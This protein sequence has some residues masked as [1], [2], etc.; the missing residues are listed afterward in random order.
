MVQPET[1]PLARYLRIFYRR[2]WWVILPAFAVFAAIWVFSWSIPAMYRS[3]TLI[4]VEHQKVPNEYVVSNIADD[5][6]QRLQTMTQQILSR[7]RLLRVIEQHGL[8]LKERTR[9]GTDEVI[10]KMRNDIQIELVRES[11][12]ELSAF[13]IAYLSRNPKT[14][15]AV[16]TQLSF[17][18]IEEN[19]RVRQERSVNTTEFLDS[20]LLEARRNLSNQEAKVRDFKGH[21]LGELP[22]QIQS[23]VQ[24]LSGMQ[25]RLQQEMEALSHAKQQRVYLE[26]M[27]SQFKAVEVGLRSSPTDKVVAPV[28][29][30]QEIE[31]LQGQLIEMR[32]RYSDEHPDV[33]KVRSQLANLIRIKELREAQIAESKAKTPTNEPAQPATFAE[34]QAI[35]PRLQVESELKANR[36]EIETRQTTIKE[37]ERQIDSYQVRLNTTPLRE[38]QLAE[39]TRDYDQSRKN[40]EQLLGKRDESSMATDL[41]K[42]QQGEQF[43]VVDPANLPQRPFSPDRL[44][45]SFMS[46]IVGLCCG[47]FSLGW[48]ILHDDAIYLRD[49][50]KS[51][52]NAPVL[53]EIP[54]LLTHSEAQRESSMATVQKVVAIALICAI[55]TGIGISYYLG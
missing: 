17:L 19:L 13:R 29:L 40:Y 25:A 49:E 20:Q 4:L 55:A 48:F 47:G 10:E 18:F 52:F 14:S 31:R 2:K 35:S 6:Q 51:I 46:V 37:I 21:Y 33:K 44:K 1:L 50:L 27:V 28:N 12:R 45:L 43:R 54:P 38:Q 26:S 30:G 16:V 42:R 23:N 3:E 53:V 24:I 5:M 32:S 39:L 22:G 9:L 34:L 8:Y 36:L 11:G 7:T 15:Q 41:E